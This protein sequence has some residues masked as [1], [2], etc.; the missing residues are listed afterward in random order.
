MSVIRKEPLIEKMLKMMNEEEKVHIAIP[1]TVTPT[2]I[3]GH[4][5]EYKD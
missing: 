4:Y 1:E 3:T 2:A 5:I